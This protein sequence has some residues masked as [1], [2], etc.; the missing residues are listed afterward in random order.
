ML[1]EI[2][3]DV[4]RWSV[5]REFGTESIDLKGMEQDDLSVGILH[6]VI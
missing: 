6:F 1:I 4:L 2:L 3:M 5:R